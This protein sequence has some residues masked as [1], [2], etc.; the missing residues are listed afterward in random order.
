MVDNPG[1]REHG[2][3]RWLTILIT[4]ASGNTDDPEPDFKEDN[5]LYQVCKVVARTLVLNWPSYGR[6][7]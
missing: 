2:S 1:S 7:P 4:R 5:E 3:Q 6:N